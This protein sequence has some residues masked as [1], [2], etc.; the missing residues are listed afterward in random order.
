[1]FWRTGM[2]GAITYA[3]LP[4]AAVGIA[5]AL[6]RVMV[7]AA[8]IRLSFPIQASVVLLLASVVLVGFRLLPQTETV[9]G[10]L[11]EN[12]AAGITYE[13]PGVILA[14]FAVACAFAVRTMRVTFDD[15]PRRREEVALTLGCGR[16]QA[17]WRVVLPEARRG[18]VTAAT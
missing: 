17:F 15:I 9:L 18:M 5:A 11:R 13:V 4:A 14:Q 10:V 8:R 1:R 2:D 6:W 16:A 7:F 12:L 3:F